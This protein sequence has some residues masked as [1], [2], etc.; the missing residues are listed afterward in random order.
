MRQ[1]SA[2]STLLKRI[3]AIHARQITIDEIPPSHGK[4][5]AEHFGARTRVFDGYG[6]IGGAFIDH[7]GFLRELTQTPGAS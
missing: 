1:S 4:W 2:S 5:L 7:A 6:H 3:L